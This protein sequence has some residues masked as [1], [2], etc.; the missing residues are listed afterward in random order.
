MYFVHAF[1][2]GRCFNAEEN[3]LIEK[4]R[5]FAIKDLDIYVILDKLQEIEKLK[6]ILLDQNQL[7][8][9]NFS[10]KP[11]IGKSDSVCTT[12]SMR[13]LHLRQKKGIL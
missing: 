13:N 11:L 12:I 3:V 7:T 5:S 2:F 10:R 6:K 8:L 4:A 9:F 1:T